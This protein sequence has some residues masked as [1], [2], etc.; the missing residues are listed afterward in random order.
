MHSDQLR[1][2]S[3]RG[4][5]ASSATLFQCIVADNSQGGLVGTLGGGQLSAIA[6]ACSITNNRGCGANFGSLYRCLIMG[7]YSTNYPAAG[8]ADAY[9]ENCLIVSNQAA[10]GGQA[11][12]VYSMTAGSARLVNC[13]LAYNSTAGGPS[14]VGFPLMTNCIIWKN[15]GPGTSE[16]YGSIDAWSCCVN[17][18]FGAGCFTNDPMFIDSLTGDLRLQSSSPCINAGQNRAMTNSL[19]Y[20][21][22]ARIA[23]GTVDVGAFEYGSP[24]SVLSYVWAQTNGVPTDGSADFTDPD[25]DG[26]NNFQEC[27]AGT[28]PTNALSVLKLLTP[29]STNWTRAVTLAWPST[30]GTIYSIERSGGAGGNFTTLRSNITGVANLATFTDTNVSSGGPY[31]YRADVQ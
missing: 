7:N 27:R 16:S 12:A 20:A 23:G 21:G 4:V 8:I 13:T 11:G 22:N 14:L 10:A 15:Y 18:A 25:G 19:D 24:A 5:G 1:D 31:F 9:V 29:T 2:K 3:E 30:F 6:I 28:I 17:P 26:M